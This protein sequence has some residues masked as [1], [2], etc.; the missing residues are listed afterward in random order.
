[1]LQ[2]KQTVSLDFLNG[3]DGHWFQVY[4]SEIFVKDEMVVFWTKTFGFA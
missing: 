2:G 4:L 3:S 1:M